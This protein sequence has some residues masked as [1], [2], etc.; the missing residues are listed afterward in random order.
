MVGTASGDTR[1]GYAFS[2]DRYHLHH[3]IVSGRII[4]LPKIMHRETTRQE[5]ENSEAESQREAKGRNQTNSKPSKKTKDHD[6]IGKAM[7]SIN[8]RDYLEDFF[9]GYLYA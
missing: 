2:F 6:Q 1:F 7:S 9:S 4:V 3:H 5:G 8:L